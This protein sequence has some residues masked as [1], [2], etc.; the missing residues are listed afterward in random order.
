MKRVCRARCMRAFLLAGLNPAIVASPT[1]PFPSCRAAVFF[2][3]TFRWQLGY[4]HGMQWFEGL[5][6]VSMSS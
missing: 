3:F 1:H 5:H 2:S 6:E 4:V